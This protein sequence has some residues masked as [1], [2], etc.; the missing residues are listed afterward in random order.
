MSSMNEGDVVTIV[1]Q[2]AK[3]PWQHLIQ[4]VET[5]PNIQYVDLEQG[6][7]IVAYSRDA[8]TCNKPVEISGKIIKVTGKNK[9]PGSKKKHSELQ[10]IV[11]RWK[12]IS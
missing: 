3:I 7:Q 2:I 4:H 11:E 8:I 9:R 6:G 12:C 5:H 1:G 10:I